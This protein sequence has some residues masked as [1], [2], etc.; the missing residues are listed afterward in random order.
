MLSGPFCR[1]SRV[2][3]FCHR[4]SW[5]LSRAGGRSGGW[6]R[7]ATPWEEG[8]W[9]DRGAPFPAPFLPLPTGPA[10]P[11]PPAPCW[12]RAG[13]GGRVGSALPG[14]P[15]DLAG[16]HQ[17]AVQGGCGGVSLDLRRHF[18]CSTQGQEPGW[19]GASPCPHQP[20]ADPSPCHPCPAAAL[21][22]TLLDLA[23][24]SSW[25]PHSQRTRC[26][27]GQGSRCPSAP[28]CACHGTHRG[29]WRSPS[30]LT[31]GGSEGE[32]RR[33]GEE[34]EPLPPHGTAHSSAARGTRR[35]AAPGLFRV[36]AEVNVHDGDVGP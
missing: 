35:A 25:L 21:R 10:V 18:L 26:A 3:S 12:G 27:P 4:N 20:V 13:G 16:E 34:A 5:G 17:R 32:K 7:V 19:V 22:V 11:A 30:A 31:S 33:E 24:P 1:G 36:L 9:R 2:P 15:Q 23:P 14:V 8:T 28:H 6:T 29:S